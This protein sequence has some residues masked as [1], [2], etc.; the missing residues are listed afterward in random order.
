MANFKE[1][2]PNINTFVFDI[3]GVLSDGSIQVTKNG[4]Q[5]RTMSTRDGIAITMA[6]KKGYNIAVISGGNSQSVL[7]RFKY[8][9]IT[10]V[11]LGIEDKVATLQHY[12]SKKNITSINVLYMGDDIPDYY[13]MKECGVATCPKDAA[14]EIK[15]IVDYISDKD[16]GKGCVRDI[17]EQVMRCNGDWFKPTN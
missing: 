14:I 10:D 6:L 12:F 15:E 5:L 17:I 11:F 13:P 16:G 2:L 4:D 1:L 8:L 3:D 9:G 7:H